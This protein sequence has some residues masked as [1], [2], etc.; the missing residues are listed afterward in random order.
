MSA[1]KNPVF[2]TT[3]KFGQM[4]FITKFVFLGKLA[5]AMMTFGFAF[6]HVLD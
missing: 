6:P 1:E 5:I 4:G 2:D 3:M